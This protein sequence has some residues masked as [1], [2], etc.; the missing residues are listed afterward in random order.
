MSCALYL[1]S[2]GLSSFGELIKKPAVSLSQALVAGLGWEVERR[3]REELPER[4]EVPSGSHLK[5]TYSAEGLP[6]LAVK[7]QEV[8]GLQTTPTVARGRLPVV[9]HLLSPA[10]RPLQVTS[11]LASFWTRTWPEVRSE[12]RSRYPKHHWPEDPAKALPSA[13]TRDR[14]LKPDGA[15]E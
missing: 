11:D 15:S 10:G 5:L 6:A 8:F 13:R 4:L 3:L 14:K 12:M 7:I 1:E 9:M 2:A